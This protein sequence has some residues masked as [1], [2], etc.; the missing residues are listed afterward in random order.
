[1]FAPHPS[2]A[3]FYRC[4]RKR[5]LLVSILLQVSVSFPGSG[6]LNRAEK[7]VHL[8][9]SPMIVL[10]RAGHHIDLFSALSCVKTTSSLALASPNFGKLTLTRRNA[11]D[12]CQSRPARH[13]LPIPDDHSLQT[14]Y[15]GI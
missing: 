1:M 4:E 3:Y 11:D 7:E 9:V 13:V 15:K 6:K 2:Q 14:M 10:K 8:S 12:P 5:I